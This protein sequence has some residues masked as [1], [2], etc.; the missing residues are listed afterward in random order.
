MKIKWEFFQ[1]LPVSVL[2]Y[3]CTTG[4]VEYA[5]YREVRPPPL[6]GPSVSHG[7]QPIMLEDRI[8]VDEWSVILV[9]SC[10]MTWSTPFQHFLGLDG[11][12]ERLRQISWLVMSSPSTYMIVLIVSFKLLL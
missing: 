11:Q 2:L 8:V 9:L 4:A 5:D 3:G 1:A 6:M 10:P 12:S 7:W